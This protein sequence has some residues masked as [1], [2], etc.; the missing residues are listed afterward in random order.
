MSRDGIVTT[1]SRETISGREPYSSNVS[2]MARPGQVNAAPEL[3]YRGYEEVIPGLLG[4]GVDAAEALVKLDKQKT[5]LEE[6]QLQKMSDEFWSNAAFVRDSSW[7]NLTQEERDRVEKEAA[8]KGQLPGDY[9]A[10]SIELKMQNQLNAQGGIPMRIS[11]TSRDK[12]YY[13][14]RF[15][16]AFAT[17]DARVQRETVA[18]E[19][20][21][22]QIINKMVE[23]GMAVIGPKGEVDRDATRQLA[24]ET[25]EANQI[26]Q[27]AD[28]RTL[29]EAAGFTPEQYQMASDTQKVQ[30]NSRL[31]QV[32]NK[33]MLDAAVKPL[34]VKMRNTD[35]ADFEKMNSYKRE[36]LT[37]L[38]EA[39]NKVGMLN[40]PPDVVTEFRNQVTAYRNLVGD[41]NLNDV[42]AANTFKA[43]MEF[44]ELQLKAKA[45]ADPDLAGQI[46]RMNSAYGPQVTAAV[47]QNSANISGDFNLS[48]IPASMKEVVIINA[49]EGQLTGSL[50]YTGNPQIDSNAYNLAQ[51]TLY[52][53]S[54]QGPTKD[55]SMNAKIKENALKIADE[56]FSLVATGRGGYTNKERMDAQR[57][58]VEMF[59]NKNSLENIDTI[60]RDNVTR[61]NLLDSSY[62]L[63]FDYAHTNAKSF[64]SGN[65]STLDLINYD[66]NKGMFVAGSDSDKTEK[67]QSIFAKPLKAIGNWVSSSKRDEA[68]DTL[69]LTLKAMGNNRARVITHN[70]T[71]DDLNEIAIQLTEDLNASYP[72]KIKIV[73]ISKEAQQ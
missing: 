72:G 55:A 27:R 41:S 43:N 24:L 32:I 50:P 20:M 1:R 6:E 31:T 68:V 36:F 51:Q 2:T 35:S 10:K 47:V 7:Q 44:S 19:N 22:N 58:A 66:V 11:A 33:L 69:N 3:K 12:Y 62:S 45:L 48:K 8:A 61:K 71:A 67:E 29:Y 37:I 28:D 56:K 73:G 21:N 49:S 25:A 53:P 30:M 64:L 63:M 13:S 14:E 70:I 5:K 52:T 26:L 15:R 23:S 17:E 9:Y 39:N 57:E 38:T 18:E 34:L 46:A 54:T 40:L 65:N 16:D 4:L 59:T 60:G 42:D